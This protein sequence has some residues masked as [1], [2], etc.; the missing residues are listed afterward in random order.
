[1]AH[2]DDLLDLADSVGAI[3]RVS[4]QQSELPLMFVAPLGTSL[5]ED[6]QLTYLTANSFSDLLKAADGSVMLFR[7][8]QQRMLEIL[9]K[10]AELFGYT[11]KA[12]YGVPGSAYDRW[13][14]EAVFGLEKVSY[15]PLVSEIRIAREVTAAKRANVRTVVEKEEKQYVR[16]NGTV[17]YDDEISVAS[18]DDDVH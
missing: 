12:L 8:D 2:Y 7:E 6:G 16:P 9:A 15:A 14:E 10:D 18:G 13:F 3:T 17:R 1:M 4:E 11:V 5:P